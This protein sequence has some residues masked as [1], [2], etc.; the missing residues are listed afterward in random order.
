[1]YNKGISEQNTQHKFEMQCRMF[2]SGGLCQLQLSKHCISWLTHVLCSEMP[3][4]FWQWSL[5]LPTFSHVKR[6]HLIHRY[7]HLMYTLQWQAGCHVLHATVLCVVMWCRWSRLCVE[8]RLSCRI[9]LCLGRGRQSG[10]VVTN[11]LF[12][13]SRGCFLQ[14]QGG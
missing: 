7:L 6:F 3:L 14:N 5:A 2:Q 1:M 9:I 10:R 12:K 4:L 11:P 13:K 8:V